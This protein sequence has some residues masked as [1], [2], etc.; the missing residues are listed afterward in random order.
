MKKLNPLE[1]LTGF[2]MG[3][4][5][6]LFCECLLLIFIKIISIW[7]GWMPLAIL[8]WMLIPVPLVFG[9]VMGQAI[10]RLHLEDY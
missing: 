1:Y 7:L 10:A 5:F 9:L 3:S 2:L 6:G 4:F 8:W